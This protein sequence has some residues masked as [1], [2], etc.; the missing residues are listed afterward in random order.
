MSRIA[1]VIAAAAG[2]AASPALAAPES[3]GPH[4]WQMMFVA[5]ASRIMEFITWFNW[6]TIIIVSLIVLFVFALMAWVIVKYNKSAHPV[7]TRVSHNTAVEV[8]WTV[9]PILIL[10]AIAVPSFRLLY[11]EYDPSKIYADFNP[12]TD[13]F[14]TVKVT[15][16]QW[17]WGVEYGND[18]DTLAF[19]VPESLGYDALMVPVDQLGAGQTAL[20]S[21][22]NPLVVPEHT[23]IRVQVTAG[24]VIH[25]FAMPAFGLKVDAVPGRL[26]ETYFNANRQGMFYGQCSELCGKDHAFMPL[27]LLVVSQDQF[28]RWGARAG[29]D[30]EGANQEL[31]AAIDAAKGNQ[32]AAR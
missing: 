9:L 5:P 12:E 17:Y 16:Y 11:A 24:D 19:G 26:N 15:G 18:P 13:K 6:Y 30:L 20:L 22:D 4:P 3:F 23:F 7:P 10:V 1:R 25:A 14:L 8:L 32:V 21:A 27:N 31:Y 28:R 29:Q 2:L